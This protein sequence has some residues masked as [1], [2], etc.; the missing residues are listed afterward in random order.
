[1][2]AAAV[3]SPTAAAAASP[4]RD[5]SPSRA[6]TPKFAGIFG[7]KRGTKALAAAAAPTTGGEAA[8]SSSLSS[9]SSKP[10]KRDLASAARAASAAASTARAV[11]ARDDGAVDDEGDASLAAIL[12]PARLSLDVDGLKDGPLVV[13]RARGSISAERARRA[14][15]AAAVCDALTSALKLDV[16]T[17]R[18][19]VGKLAV[20]RARGHLVE[21]LATA[22]WWADTVA[23]RPLAPRGAGNEPVFREVHYS[24]AMTW[25]THMEYAAL[26]HY[27]V[28]VAM[29]MSAFREVH[30]TRDDVAHKECAAL[31][32]Y[33]VTA[34]MFREVLHSRCYGWRRRNTSPG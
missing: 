23:R 18:L 10:K 3:A 11:I 25:L 20:S 19:A 1:M 32:R 6:S 29:I 34:A 9:S 28:M 5:A 13:T 17:G 4:S 15:R 8:A 27:D 21:L 24:R 26:K 7:G 2:P 22:R 12:G 16:F 33:D 31:K 14:A 30:F